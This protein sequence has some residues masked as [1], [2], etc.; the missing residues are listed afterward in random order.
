[1]KQT[2]KEL[3]TKKDEDGRI[4]EKYYQANSHQ[5]RQPVIPAVKLRGLALLL[6]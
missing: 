6:A 1:M 3:M 5:Q 4:E 2:K